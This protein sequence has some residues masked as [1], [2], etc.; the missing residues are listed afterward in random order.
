VDLIQKLHEQSAAGKVAPLIE[1]L[2]ADIDY[3]SL[4]REESDEVDVDRAANV[5]E[6]ISAARQYDALGEESEELVKWRRRE[7][8]FEDDEEEDSEDSEDQPLIASQPEAAASFMDA[9]EKTSLQGFLELA[10]LANEAD[11]VD[12]SKGSVTLMTLHAS[13]GLEFP[14]VYII[15]IESGLIP[16]ERAVREGDPAS[17]EEERR[18]LF[19]GITRAM[20]QLTLTQTSERTFRG[21]RRATISSP[22]VPELHGA[23]SRES[24]MATPPPITEALLDQR[25]E[26]ARRR[27]EAAQ[28]T[29]G[30][31]LIMTAAEL[32][33]RQALP[34]EGTS[35]DTAPAFAFRQGMQV[36]HPRY[37]RGVVIE[38]SGGS[39]RATITV[40]F[41]NEE[42][43]HTF[44]AS[45][46]PLQPIGLQ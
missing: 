25:L 36:R 35:D 1:R 7:S 28:K 3:L 27:F 30:H 39:H 13:K 5:H 17:F 2:I 41:E 4:W 20:R 29:G 31:K 40:Q 18:L 34:E 42:Q 9:D 11:S 43:T 19:V 14:S 45:R 22:F 15:G 38:L 8:A 46:C 33:A 37:G 23:I 10:T 6:L 12:A 32:A 26:Q 44:V 16:H 24:S 21:M